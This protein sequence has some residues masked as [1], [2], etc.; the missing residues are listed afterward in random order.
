MTNPVTSDSNTAGTVIALHCSLGSG[1]QWARLTE[2]F[3]D[4]HRVIA[5]D[6]SG[7]GNNVGTFELPTTLTEEVDLLLR[8]PLRDA[9]GPIHLV[10]HSYGGALAFKIATRR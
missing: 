1:K 5:P 3:A 4:K 7:Y 9:V 6:I 8:D 10:G 2:G